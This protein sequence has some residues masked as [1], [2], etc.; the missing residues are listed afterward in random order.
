MTQPS[1]A[2]DPAGADAPAVVQLSGSVDLE[3]SPEVRRRLL[4]CVAKAQRL[5]IDLSE[6]TYIDSSGIACLV[7]ALQSARSKDGDLALVSVSMQAMRVLELARL[8]MVFSIHEDLAA[9]RAA[10]A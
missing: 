9:A 4:D 3:H 7:E 5:L 6:V 1:A 8:D 10:Q 2:P